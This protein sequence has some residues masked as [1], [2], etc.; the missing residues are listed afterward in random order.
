MAFTPFGVLLLSAAGEEEAG[1]ALGPAS[2]RGVWPGV[3]TRP[4][5]ARSL[6][7]ALS[8]EHLF[9]RTRGSGGSGGGGGG[10]PSAD[11]LA[12]L[13]DEVSLPDSPPVDA[14]PLLEARPRFLPGRPAPL[15]PPGTSCPRWV[16]RVSR[17]P[18]TGPLLSESEEE[19]D[20]E[21]LERR[22]SW[23]AC[24]SLVPSSPPSGGPSTRL[25]LGGC[26]FS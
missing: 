13:A 26:L 3:S 22:P 18:P 14:L 16:E 2:L 8:A 21:D 17:R 24:S 20:S 5:I 15:V 4:F 6:A 23:S 7:A 10:V 1:G 25:F 12:V 19:E 9:P 11:L